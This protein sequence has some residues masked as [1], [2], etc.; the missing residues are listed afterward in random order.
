MTETLRLIDTH[1]HLA[2]PQFDADREQAIAR[3]AAAGVARI[4]EIGYDLPSS[5]AAVALA[6]A[7]PQI[8]AVVGVQPNHVHELAEGWEAELRALCAH[9]RVLAIGEIGL[10]YHW[11]KA[12]PELQERQFRA[13][14]AMARELGLPAVIHTREAR[15]DTARILADAARGQPVIRHSFSG[16]WAFA[17]ICLELGFTL[18]FSGPLTF[19]KAAELHE[20]ARRAPL[21]RLLVETDSPYL[22]PHPHRGKRNEPAHVR[23]VA[24][25][26]AALREEPLAAVAAQLWENAERI[27]PRM[28][29]L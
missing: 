2:L 13:Q 26:L 10:D 25:R 23:L 18:S 28:R 9:P 22:A 19:P 15:D 6:A 3:A 8:F 29:Q 12:P 27:F 11:M 4:V 16:D 24:E 1:A 5:R 7:H 20:V 14:L 17:T 21:D